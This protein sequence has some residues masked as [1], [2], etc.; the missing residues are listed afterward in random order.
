VE[1]GLERN[2]VDVRRSV[3]FKIHLSIYLSCYESSSTVSSDLVESEV[4]S[5]PIPQT[6]VISFYSVRSPS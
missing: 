6:D 5:R 3:S 4:L 1:S 2:G